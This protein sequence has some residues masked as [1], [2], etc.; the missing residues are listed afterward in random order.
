M[1]DRDSSL[2]HPE[3]AVIPNSCLPGLSRIAVRI[4]ML[5]LWIS[6]TISREQLD[7]HG[8]DFNIG[9]TNTTL[10]LVQVTEMRTCKIYVLA[11][12]PEEL[13]L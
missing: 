13:P 6:K 8:K 4:C 11:R 2:L 12:S 9:L 7:G 1:T 3:L 10:S 5:H